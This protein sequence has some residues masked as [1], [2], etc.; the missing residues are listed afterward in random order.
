MRDAV[1][2]RVDYH[3]LLATMGE[4][5]QRIRTEIDALETAVEDGRVSYV[6]VVASV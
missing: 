2:D 3:G 6:S 5:C 1:T 4:R